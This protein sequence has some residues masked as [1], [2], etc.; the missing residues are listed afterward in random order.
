MSAFSRLFCG[1]LSTI[2]AI[3]EICLLET[4]IYASGMSV[5]GVESLRE[6]PKGRDGE[7]NA[8]NCENFRF[9]IKF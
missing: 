3:S 2:A 8:E 5:K 7:R 9:L 4:L 1:K 6:T